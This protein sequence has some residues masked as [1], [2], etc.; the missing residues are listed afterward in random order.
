MG[1]ESRQTVLN[2][3]HFKTEHLPSELIY[4]SLIAYV[5]FTRAVVDLGGFALQ[6]F[7]TLV[8]SYQ[9]AAILWNI[10]LR[11]IPDLWDI[12]YWTFGTTIFSASYVLIMYGVAAIAIDTWGWLK[13][14]WG[15]LDPLTNQSQFIVITG[16]ITLFAGCLFYL[17]R[18]KQRFLYGFT[19]ACIGVVVGMHRV[20]LEQWPEAPKNTDFYLALLTASIYL[21]VRGIDNMH[22]A[23]RDNDPTLQRIY[24]F[25]LR[26]SL[27][28]RIT[29]RVSRVRAVRMRKTKKIQR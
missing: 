19:E 3:L 11:R 7:L 21:V 20:T 12:V 2:S 9:I 13:S 14:F 26:K 29:T 23:Y 6:A 28:T 24:R 25:F 10:W 1:S 5:L 18:I 27:T 16:L 4:G 15:Q 17:F 8:A 22:Q